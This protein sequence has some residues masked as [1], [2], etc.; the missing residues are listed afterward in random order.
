MLKETRLSGHHNPSSFN[1]VKGPL[2]N[3]DV[4]LK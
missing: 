4:Q 1:S 3:A 2:L